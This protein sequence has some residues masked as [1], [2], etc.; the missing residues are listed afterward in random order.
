MF[1]LKTREDRC[2]QLSAIQQSLRSIACL[3]DAAMVL[4]DV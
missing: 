4:I 1:F 3:D 2:S